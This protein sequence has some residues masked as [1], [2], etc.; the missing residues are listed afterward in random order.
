MAKKGVEERHSQTAMVAALYRAVT[1]IDFKDQ[2]LAPDYLAEN[3]LPSFL[4]F[5]IKFN[6][7]RGS[8]YKKYEKFT[9]GMYSFMLARTAFFD[10]VFKD[11]LE[12]EIPQIVLLGG[13]YDTRAFR[14]AESNKTTRVFDLDIKTTQNRKVKC[15]QKAQLDVP[16]RVSL[17]PIDFNNESLSEVLEKAGYEANKKTAFFWEGVIYYLEPQSVDATLKFVSSNSHAESTIAF[18]YAI[19]ITDQNIDRYFGAKEFLETW[20]KHRPNESFKSTVE[21]GKL[22]SF[23]ESRDLKMVEHYDPEGIEKTFLVNHPKESTGQ[24]NGMFAFAVASPVSDQ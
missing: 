13:G 15:L 1:F 6:W 20:R 22:D 11:A 5:L 21:D 4:R 19:T 17:V 16:E 3:F 24:I 23:L 10:K 18:D 7:I 2:T 8:F 12:N 14:F 9:P